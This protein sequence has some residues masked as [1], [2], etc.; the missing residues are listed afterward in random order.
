MVWTETTRKE[1]CRRRLRFA[2]D[3]TDAEWSLVAGL[4]PAAG[5]RGRPRRVDLRRV[6]EA[7]QYVLWTSCPWRALPGEFPARS[8]VQHYFYK[9]RAAGVFD[10]LRLPVQQ[11]RRAMGRNAQP[12]AA[13]IDSQSVRTTESG[14]PRGRDP[15]KRLTGRKRHI[16][17]DTNG[18]PLVM[19]VHSADIQDVHGAV[20][21]LRSLRQ[22][23][24]DLSLVFADRVYRGKQLPAALAD[25]GPWNIEIVER[26]KGEKGFQLLPRRWVV[27]RTFAWLGRCRRLQRDCERSIE[28]SLA[29]LQLAA[30]RFLVRRLARQSTNDL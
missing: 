11:L 3:L 12:S 15:A 4:L 16:V 7:I 1:H 18:L 21:L 19:Q 14:G 28:S 22:I 5:R 9:W 25:C 2:S 29:W 8:T 27:E 26:P 13:I 23:M 10:C 30:L 17:T 20:P 6:F 24:P